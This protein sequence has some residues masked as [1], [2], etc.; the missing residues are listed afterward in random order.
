[1][2]LVNCSIQW[3]NLELD[4]WQQRFEIIPR[5]N[6]LQSYAYARAICP[7]KGQRVKWGLILIDGAEAGLLQV[8]EA[9]LFGNIIHNVILDRGPLWFPGFGTPAHLAAF[10]AEFNRLFPRRMGRARRLIPETEHPDI[11]HILERAGFRIRHAEEYATI[12]V[13]LTP[14]DATLRQNLHQKWRNQLNKSF[15]QG[16]TFKCDRQGRTMPAF[17]RVYKESKNIKQ[18]QN[19]KPQDLT[20]FFK[21]FSETN[22]GFLAYALYNGTIAAAALVLIHGQSATW[23]IGYISDEGRSLCA[24]HFLLWHIML[25][26]K[27]HGLKD[28]D[29]GGINQ[30]HAGGLTTFKE[31]LN[32]TTFKLQGIYS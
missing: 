2:T 11:T 25:I 4:A 13:D 3:N 30:A 10:F 32:G 17:L 18:Y 24:N 14:D 8:F 5:S 9:G 23:Q 16:L 28:L 21:C 12:W 29:L 1:M 6:L 22:N 15:K 31:G 27:E 19:I 26:L 20:H 7:L